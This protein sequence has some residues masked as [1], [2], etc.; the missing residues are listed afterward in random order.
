MG[1]LAQ[2][3]AQP[4]TELSAEAWNRALVAIARQLPELRGKPGTAKP[5]NHPWKVTAAQDERPTNTDGRSWKIRTE[6]GCVNDTAA[7]FVYRAQSDP[8]GWQAPST[9]DA[10]RT[11]IVDRTMLETD[12]PPFIVLTAPAIN[13]TA[14][15]LDDFQPVPDS[16]RPT[17]FRTEEMWKVLLFQ[18]YVVLTSE[19]RTSA[20]PSLPPNLLS[21]LPQRYRVSAGRK[22]VTPTALA[23]GLQEIARLYL[24]RDP[25][26]TDASEDTITVR[27][28]LFWD[29]AALYVEPTNVLENYGDAG[30][31]G[32][33][34]EGEVDQTLQDAATMQFWTA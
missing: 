12:D 27:Q 18:A 9:I 2:Y 7:A 23:G 11:P 34:V 17:F 25:A 21:R 19:P 30:D 26:S 16:A 32:N 5:F 28:L 3:Y 6:L 15:T 22:P 20:S 31:Y 4:G 24:L 14:T 8:R 29:I 33:I 1:S 13:Q 10:N